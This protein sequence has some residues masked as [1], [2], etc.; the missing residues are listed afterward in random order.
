MIVLL[1]CSSNNKAVNLFD[2]ALND[3]GTPSKIWTVKNDEHFRIWDRITELRAE[4]CVNYL[5]GLSVHN[6]QIE[7]FWERSDLHFTGLTTT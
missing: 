3:F 6:Q 4:N 7:R 5:A 1:Y 2:Y